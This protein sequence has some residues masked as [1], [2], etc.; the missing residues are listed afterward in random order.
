MEIC[1]LWIVLPEIL[2]FFNFLKEFYR[3]F[4]ENCANNLG[5]YGRSDAFVGGSGGG[6]KI[7]LENPM[8]TSNFLKNFMNSDRIFLFKTLILIK[9]IRKA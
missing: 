6:K 8:E 5:K 4:R 1:N 2:P 3:I 7:V 9:K